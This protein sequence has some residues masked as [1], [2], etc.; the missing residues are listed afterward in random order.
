MTTLIQE[1]VQQ[2]IDI[3]KEKD[4]D[5][6][7]IFVRETSVNSDPI[8]PVIYGNETLTRQSA[9]L[10]HQT[11]ETIAIVGR[12]DAE[13]TRLIGAYKMVIPCDAGISQHLLSEL[14]RLNPAKI[15]INTSLSNVMADGLSYGMYQLLV[16]MLADTIFIDRLC[17]AEEIISALNGRKTPSEISLIQAAVDETFEIYQQTYNFMQ[18]GQTEKDVSDFM[19]Q[20]LADRNLWLPGP[21]KVARQST[22]DRIPR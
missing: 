13:T 21:M 7:L 20:Q 1:K 11:G 14:Q 8:L 22:V 3:L 4:I 9:L 15:A 19:H 10:I 12:I 5:L 17:S 6:W 16:K 2:A 18:P